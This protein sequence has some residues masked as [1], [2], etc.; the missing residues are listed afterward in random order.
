MLISCQTEKKEDIDIVGKWKGYIVSENDYC[1]Y[2]ID[3][4]SIGIFY[5]SG[6]NGGLIEYKIEKDTLFFQEEKFTLE[7]ISENLF[8]MTIRGKTDT[9]T[10]L[11]NSIITFHSIEYQNDSIFDNFYEKFQNRVYES[12]IEHGYVT[13]EELRNS[14]IK[15]GNIKEKITHLNE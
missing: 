9:L 6:G 15:K 12:W 13:E 14:F 2:D 4:D 11:P 5:H 1:E 7:V 3:K 8:T 10:R